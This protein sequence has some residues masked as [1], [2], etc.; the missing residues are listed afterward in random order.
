MANSSMRDTGRGP[1]EAA[2]RLFGALYDLSRH[3]DSATLGQR[4]VAVVPRIVACDSAV[5]ARIQPA[6]RTFTFVAWPERSFES[7]DHSEV[8]ALHLQDHPLIAHFAARRDAR[9]WSLHDFVPESRF[10][11][12]PLY[13]KLYRPLGVEY[14]LAMLI[15][16][17]DRDQRVLALN[18]RDVPFSEDE[19]C[20]LEL[21]WPHLAQAVRACRGGWRRPKIPEIDSL[22]GGRGVIVLNRT[23]KVELCT[24]QARIWLTRYCIENYSGR[25]I[26]ALPEPIEAWVANALTNRALQARGIGDPSSALILRRGDQY[27]AMRLVTDHGRGQHLVLME[28]A[29][30]NTPPDL[31]LGLG[32]TPREAE[33][34]AWVAQGKTNRET[35]MILGTSTRTVQK[36]LERVFAKLGVESRTGAILKAWQTGRFEDLAPQR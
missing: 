22:A 10:R 6:T 32:L 20:T 2:E 17:V 1:P 7:I 5:F 9:A 30:M 26:R 15:P 27:L 3:R 28:E 29:A 25:E 16:S 4:I 24:E 36:H 14:Q 21:T 31:L 8:I 33:V 18:R 23:G 13:R 34:L 35:A 11:R 12:T 19:K